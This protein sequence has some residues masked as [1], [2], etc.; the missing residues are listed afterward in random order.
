MQTTL[1]VAI[2]PAHRLRAAYFEP[3]IWPQ[4]LADVTYVSRIA[5]IRRLGQQL[6]VFPVAHFD[7]S[8]V[9]GE[10]SSLPL[11]HPSISKGKDS[12]WNEALIGNMHAISDFD[13]HISPSYH[14]AWFATVDC[15]A[16]VHSE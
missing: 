4:S 6:T 5:E 16:A 10:V 13:Q 1:H 11:L 14:T 3:F 15:L 9:G 7:D 2:S 8:S 12:S